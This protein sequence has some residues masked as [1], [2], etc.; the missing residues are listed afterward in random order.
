MK[1]SLTL[2]EL[3]QTI[4]RHNT[5]KRDFVAD[6]RNL[7][8][9]AIDVQGDTPKRDVI[10]DIKG[11]GFRNVDRNAHRQIAARAKIPQQ[12]YDRML[13]DEPELLAENV[14][15]WWEHEPEKRMVRTLG[16][17]TRAFLSERYRPLD[18]Y[19]LAHAVL[20]VLMEQPEM[21][22]ES[23]DVNEHRMMIKAL[24]PRIEGEITT[25]DP[26]QSGLVISNNEVGAGGLNVSP[27]V[28]RLVCSNGM[29]AQSAL[30]K[31][32]VGRALGNGE[33]DSAYELYRDETLAADD[34]A[35]WLKVQDTVRSAVTEAA[36]AAQVDRLKEAAGIRL[37]ADPVKVVESTAAKFGLN[38]AE[39]GSVLTHL[40][41][42]GDLTQ[43]GLLNAVTR[44]SQDVESYDR[45]TE[46]ER[47]GGRI[48]ELNRSEWSTITQ[49]A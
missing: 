21:K 24:F 30:R 13:T 42:G 31:A 48:L 25:G 6:T 49:A 29:I 37:E 2:T 34:K 33:N 23:C 18:N 38:D 15:T 27:L 44:A 45:A 3:A 26:V 46:L 43:W 5:E 40:I 41:E 4:E 35:F 7:E 9:Q 36:F 20:P 22:V 10:L 16:S 47:A 39:R 11:I 8:L 19:E 14:N 12:Y 28:Y 17:N 32:H 1:Q